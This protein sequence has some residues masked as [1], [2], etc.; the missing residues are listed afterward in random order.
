MLIKTSA[1][2]LSVSSSLPATDVN[3]LA[4]ASPDLKAT[5]VALHPI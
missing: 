2:H 5:A 3:V 1:A 4:N